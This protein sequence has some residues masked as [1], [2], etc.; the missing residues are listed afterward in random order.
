MM[1]VHSAG[2]RLY[3][4]SSTLVVLSR[5]SWIR[6]FSLSLVLIGRCTECSVLCRVDYMLLLLCVRQYMVCV[7]LVAFCCG[8]DN[9]QN[10]MICLV[11][12]LLFD[13]CTVEECL[14]FFCKS[15]VDVFVF[16]L[17]LCV[18]RRARSAMYP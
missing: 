6:G 13:A 7:V 11:A 12:L 14:G 1:I 16:Y 3:L 5:L 17:R 2:R 8:G 10:S 9:N 4:I 15:V 18:R